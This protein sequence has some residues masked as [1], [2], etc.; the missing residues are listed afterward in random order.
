MRDY[1]NITNL[2]FEFVDG[3]ENP[4]GIQEKAWLIPI[5]WLQTEGKPVAEG[6]TAASIATIAV[7]H[8][9]KSGKSPIL[10]NAL[11]SKSGSNFKLAGEELSKMF[12]DDSEFFIPQISADTI[13]GAAAIKNMRF[14]ILMQRPGQLVGFWQVGTSGMSAKVQDIVG[15]LGTGSTSE[16]GLKISLKA[17]DVVPMYNYTG[18][19]PV[20]GA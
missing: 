14:M 8:T 19:L 4:S 5:S 7:N 18:E 3:L 1:K 20:A 2:G 12:E 17:F 15:G 10:V 9:L 11:N 6:T 16:V 13:G